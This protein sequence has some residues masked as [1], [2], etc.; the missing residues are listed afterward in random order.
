MAKKNNKQTELNKVAK[1]IMNANDTFNELMNTIDVKV[2]GHNEKRRS[3][4]DSLG[5]DISSYSF[6]EVD[7]YADI[8]GS[9]FSSLVRKTFAEQGQ[10]LPPN[11]Q[12]DDL[13]R[14]NDNEIQQFFDLRYKSRMYLYD[15]LELVMS[16]MAELKEAVY[17][18]RDSIVT[19]DGI[20]TGI[21]REL[22]FNSA[23]ADMQDVYIKQIEEMEKDLK[24]NKKIKDIIVPKTLQYGTEYVYTI[25]YADILKR[26][27]A[28]N[29]SGD[30]SM[31]PTLNSAF[32]E[33]ITESFSVE[34]SNMEF[35]TESYNAQ[36]SSSEEDKID[37]T[38]MVESCNALLQNI[39]VNNNDTPIPILENDACIDELTALLKQDRV[40]KYAMKAFDSQ[41]DMAKSSDISKGQ[42]DHSIY[43]D[44]VKDINA[45]EKGSRKKKGENFDDIKGTYIKT[46][47]PKQIIPITILNSYTI[48][49]Y[50]AREDKD[51]SRRPA[52]TATAMNPNFNNHLLNQDIN[53]DLEKQLVSN[54]TD[55][56]VKSF[57][58]KYLE[59]NAEFKEMIINSLLFDE[60]Y[61]KNVV[62][63]FLPA[64]LVTK[65]Y[66]NSDEE[67]YGT[68]ILTDALF[69]AKLYLALLL[70][71]MISIISQSNDTRIYNIKQSSESADIGRQ[72]QRIMREVKRHDMNY[73]DLMNYNS[74]STKLGA[75]KSIFMPIGPSGEPTVTF[76]IL[77]GRDIQL[78]TE[79]MEMLK[80]AAI[81]A[82]GVPSVIMQYLNE[83][84]YAKTLEVAN[85]KFAN[86]ISSYQLDFNECI[87]DL[88]KKL[89]RQCTT[90][91]E[92]IIESFEYVLQPPNASNISNKQ[93]QIQ[94]ADSMI[95]WMV[96]KYFG[97]Q[98]EDEDIETKK[99]IAKLSLSKKLL[100]GLPWDVLDD[101]IDE[102]NLKVKQLKAEKELT[103]NS[104]AEE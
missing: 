43:A 28:M 76:D 30:G 60:M 93:E 19:A 72:V 96:E 10:P 71:K 42:S 3:E 58:R 18:T 25:S 32:P 87:T 67:G 98:G 40:N 31:M 79:L 13:F 99:N 26:Y 101:E 27:S 90:I 89:M 65:F 57:N 8:H 88:Y 16:Q 70:F 82:T 37:T 81:N 95:E 15:D 21:L 91:P 20:S 83:A 94:N 50:W 39:R 78:N 53:K 1:P 29:A 34:D 7:K 68:S 63:Q 104:G 59:D 12:I 62:F 33:S 36:Y 73:K 102:I 56:I 54:L 61:K 22:K 66:V 84:D 69:N 46:I 41:S 9:D 5:N 4:I 86:R 47:N 75:N 80:T 38:S 64:D 51:F 48:G 11:M 49:Y 44:A 14:A 23:S 35:L 92:E 77:A 24:I 6:N 85:I 17:T 103:G 52:S 97:A 2:T 74:L 45:L 55:K 100:T